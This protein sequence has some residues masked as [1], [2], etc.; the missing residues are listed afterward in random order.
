MTQRQGTFR[1]RRRVLLGL[2]CAAV[3][4]MAWQSFQIQVRDTDRWQAL[5]AGQHSTSA[6]VAAARGRIL[7]R[8][9]EALA[10]SREVYSVAVAPGEVGDADFVAG[11]LATA[12]D[13]SF[14]DAR[15]LATSDRRWAVLP[16]RFGP[17]VREELHRVT[18]VYV[19]REKTRS[20]P[21]EELVRGLLGSVVDDHGAG[22]VEQIYDD[23][24]RG[25]PGS[26]VVARGSDGEP[27]AGESQL[28]RPPQPGGEVALTLDRG[29]QEIA[30]HALASALEDTGAQGGDVLVTRPATGEILAMASERPGGA[31]YLPALTATYEP[32][33]TLKPFTI[34]GL[35]RHDLASLDEKVDVED[36]TWTTHGRTITDVETSDTTT[37]ITLREAVRRSSNV[38]V[39]RLAERMTEEQQYETLRDFGFGVPTGLELPGEAGGVLRRPDAWSRQSPASLAIGYELGATPLQMAMAY[40]ALANGGELMEPR[41]VREVRRP[42]GSAK[43][44]HDPRSVRQVVSEDVA[45][46]LRQTLAEAVSD[47]TG[48]QADLETVAVAGKTG[49]TRAH[50]PMGYQ[51]GGYQASFVG[52]L[53]ADD[54]ELLVYVRLDDPQGEYYGGATAA[55]ASRAVMEALVASP[56]ALQQR[57]ALASPALESPLASGFADASGRTA[58]RS[59]GGFEEGRPDAEGSAGGVSGFVALDGVAG[60]APAA[61]MVRDGG[62]SWGGAASSGEPGVRLV[63][64]A[65]APAAGPE[66][67]G[68]TAAGAG[69]EPE[70]PSESAETSNGE[71]AE[72]PV[73]IPEVEGLS[74]R[75]AVGALHEEGL[76]ARIPSGDGPYTTVPEPGT[77]V[78]MGDTVRLVPEGPS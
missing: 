49:T 29:L 54:P 33:S 31:S 37:V 3:V 67:G 65:Q 55:P 69:G 9:D 56:G 30:H 64:A 73:R 40:G 36:G 21:R 17:E 77:E 51:S 38:G 57:R 68:P 61:Q 28:V 22:G 6:D 39:A 14:D 70:D 42:D 23:V 11:R 26:R 50:G 35:L 44:R 47:G 2:W 20:Y 78:G 46:E 4:V 66:S 13:I 71:V 34:A 63:S 43:E 8:N 18:G 24:L 5:A 7:D 16:G 59:T 75:Q 32:G 19:D 52:F 10:T 45:A 41:F 76:R 27:I 53:P 60:E 74:L 72:A 58:N 1:L 15:R 25:E 48:A 12:L 62:P